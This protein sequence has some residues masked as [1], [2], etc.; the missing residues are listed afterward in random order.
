MVKLWDYD[1]FWIIWVSCLD[2][3]RTIKDIQ[4][5]WGYEANALYQKGEKRPIWQEMLEKGFLEQ[6]GRVRKR[7]AAGILLY[8]KLD[9]LLDYLKSFFKDLRVKS[10]NPLPSHL[11]DCFDKNKLIKFLEKKRTTFFFINR[12]K[13]LFGNKENLKNNPE[14]C[15]FVPMIVLLNFFIISTLK[16]RMKLGKET[17]FLVTQSLVFNI[18]LKVNLVKYTKELL[19][20]LKTGGIPEGLIDERKVFQVWKRYAEE[21]YS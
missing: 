8:G 3:P 11:F 15:F 5:F 18:G 9:W 10:E 1:K 12:I 4:K 21:I 2:K 14:M 19:T 6:R 20:E 17:L 13:V 7:G 16:K